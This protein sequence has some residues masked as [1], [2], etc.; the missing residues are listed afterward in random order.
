MSNTRQRLGRWGEAAAAAYLQSR[1][2][3]VLEQNLRT[4][5]GEIDI[6]AS[7]AGSQGSVVVFVEVKTRTSNRYGYPEASITAAKQA[8]LLAAI[9]YYWQQH[10]EVEQD[11]RVD[12]ISIERPRSGGPA[13]I[14]HFENAL[15]A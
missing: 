7:Q 14:T 8:H 13:T 3:I 11:W 12:V 15:N 5:H 9:Q 2:Y 10:P 4:P 1:G 6:V